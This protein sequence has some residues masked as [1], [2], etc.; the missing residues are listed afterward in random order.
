MIS[1][2]LR[3]AEAE[4]NFVLIL[5]HCLILQTFLELN[6]ILIRTLKATQMD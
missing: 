5:Y 3:F 2:I 1:I 6:H 4:N